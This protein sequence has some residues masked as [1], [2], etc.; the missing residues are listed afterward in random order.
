LEDLG[1]DNGIRD[2]GRLLA[3]QSSDLDLAG[4]GAGLGRLGGRSSGGLF[5]LDGHLDIRDGGGSGVGRHFWGD[6]G[7]LKGSR[8]VERA[9]LRQKL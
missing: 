4:L 8:K 7:R 9:F 5:G 3:R 1:A 2:I 6:S